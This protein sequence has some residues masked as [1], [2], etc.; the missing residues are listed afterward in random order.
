MNYMIHKPAQIVMLLFLLLSIAG[1]SQELTRYNLLSPL[2]SNGLIGIHGVSN[3]GDTLDMG[4]L[5]CK[6]D[7]VFIYG[8]SIFH[9]AN[10]CYF[11]AKLDSGYYNDSGYFDAIMD[12]TVRVKRQ[13]FAMGSP[14]VVVWVDSE[15]A[16]SSN[17]FKISI[18]LVPS[19]RHGC[20]AQLNLFLDEFGSLMYFDA[21]YPFA[22]EGASPLSRCF[23]W[24]LERQVPHN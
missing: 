21:Y 4:Y 23:P 10:S 14:D 6:N 12:S 11:M 20:V 9:W 17:L 3:N 5:K 22:D 13:K 1:I 16:L 7:S 18:Y 2:R 19:H 8:D 24:D 15:K